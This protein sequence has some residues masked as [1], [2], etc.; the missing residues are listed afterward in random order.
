MSFWNKKQQAPTP[1]PAPVKKEEKEREASLINLADEAPQIDGSVSGKEIIENEPTDELETYP[2]DNF[3]VEEISPEMTNKLIHPNTKMGAIGTP[4]MP[5]VQRNDT[6]D[7]NIEEDP[8]IQAMQEK[9]AQM[10]EAKRIA[11]EEARKRA[12]DA[13]RLQLAE[14][15]KYA[16]RPEVMLVDEKQML[17]MIYDK[18]NNME[19]GLVM[20][21]DKLGRN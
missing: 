10:K 3:S 5:K 11:A 4:A 14:L 16:M 18:L 20:L 13:Q 15:N 17:Q 6:F 1:T 8:E 21:A 19:M 9:L 12:E 7:D 2:D